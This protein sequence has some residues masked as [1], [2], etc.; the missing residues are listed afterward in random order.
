MG[1]AANWFRAYQVGRHRPSRGVSDTWPSR[2]LLTQTKRVEG[3][4]YVIIRI[5]QGAHLT[6]LHNTWRRVRRAAG[7][8]DTRIDALRHT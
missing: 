4:P 6:D 2:R 1:M 8:E 5:A 3:N 7:L